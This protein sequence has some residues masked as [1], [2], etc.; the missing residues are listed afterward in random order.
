MSLPTLQQAIAAANELM[1]ND[2]AILSV[3]IEF[4]TEAGHKM[5]A[6]WDGSIGN[7]RLRD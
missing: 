1:Q 5:I 2:K 3:E 4:I 6:E 7:V